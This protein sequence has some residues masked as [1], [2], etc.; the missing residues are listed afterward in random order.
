MKVVN[1]GIDDSP[2]RKSE[3]A[4]LVAMVSAALADGSVARAGI[5]TE[6]LSEWMAHPKP[7]RVHVLK[8][9]AEALEWKA[10]FILGANLESLPAD[11]SAFMSADLGGMAMEEARR[12][13]DPPPF[14]FMDDERG[15]ASGTCT[16]I[17]FA[18][19]AIAG[20]ECVGDRESRIGFAGTYNMPDWFERE[21]F[22]E[23]VREE[24]RAVFRT[25]SAGWMRLFPDSHE[26]FNWRAGLWLDSATAASR[27][28]M[29]EF[30]L[31]QIGGMI[32]SAGYT[33]SVQEGGGRRMLVSV[34]VD[35][36][37]WTLANNP[38]FLR[39]FISHEIV[40]HVGL[41]NI[42]DAKQ[43][44]ALIG[45]VSG[46]MGND[47]RMM[48]H[49]A[50]SLSRSGGAYSE[51]EI[52]D[53]ILAWYFEKA[54]DGDPDFLKGSERGAGAALRKLDRGGEG[55]GAS[56]ISNLAWKAVKYIRENSDGSGIAI[57]P[58]S[59]CDDCHPADGGR[60]SAT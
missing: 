18:A 53:E 22:E 55:I 42:L 38:V 44:D 13:G 37:A 27:S 20:I 41:A 43:H 33:S 14:F 58:G 26:S 5:D 9:Q 25:D 10:R 30:L 1:F 11:P 15:L 57:Q 19:D 31:G 45:A 40:A 35:K 59:C 8:D 21:W 46:W 23:R 12:D 16:H 24:A 2:E 51:A 28:F 48:N 34:N 52:D 32:P 49:V 6:E 56:D 39:G 4:A 47:T 7:G 60:V 29:L 50:E 3:Q 17:A 54:A 36:M